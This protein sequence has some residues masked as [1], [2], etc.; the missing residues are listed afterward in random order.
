MNS[1]FD[2]IANQPYISSKTAPTNG[3]AFNLFENRNDPRHVVTLKRAH[4]QQPC[5]KT[6]G[7]QIK[8]TRTLFSNLE[9]QGAASI[10]SGLAAPA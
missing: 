9:Y 6:T 5:L 3:C 7:R 2:M 10:A 8:F 4:Q 1:P